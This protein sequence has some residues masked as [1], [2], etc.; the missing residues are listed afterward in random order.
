MDAKADRKQ[1]VLIVHNIHFEPVDLEQV[2][3]EKFS[4]A[5]K[6][7][8]QFNQCQDIIFKKSN[9]EEYLNVIS[10]SFS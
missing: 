8:V 5:L 1:K 10:K 2:I 6:E 9:N 3:L 7:F 4:Q